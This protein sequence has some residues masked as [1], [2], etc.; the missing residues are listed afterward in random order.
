VVQCRTKAAVANACA[1]TS[2]ADDDAARA[3]GVATQFSVEGKNFEDRPHCWYR[4]FYA[5]EGDARF[6]SHL[7]LIQVFFQAFR[8]AG[9]ALH[10][11]QGFNPVPKASFSP[12]LPV[13]TA[14]KAEF[15]D[16][17]LTDAIADKSKFLLHL[18]R[19][20]PRGIS[21]LSVDVVPGKMSDPDVKILPCYRI[22]LA[23]ELSVADSEI[24]QG[25]MAAE[26]FIVTKTR[27]GRKRALD[28]RKQ[29]KNIE[30]TGRDRLELILQ[31]EGNKAASK[32]AE[33]L[34][35]VLNLSDSESLDLDILKVWSRAAD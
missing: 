9:V 23:R 27:K 20:L 15:L 26:S 5:K 4:L 24:L 17:D 10:H 33:I 11:T 32:P 22:C 6:L 8:R 16:V 12:A 34:Q 30:V 14:S 25:F 3:G 29:V 13:G 28:I 31:Y 2:G 35:A 19:N 18:N 1:E 21:I 7:E